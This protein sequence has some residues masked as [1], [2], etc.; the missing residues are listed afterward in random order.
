MMQAIVR[1]PAIGRR[2]L[3]EPEAVIAR[4]A[5]GYAIDFITGPAAEAL[6]PGEAAGFEATPALNTCAPSDSGPVLLRCIKVRFLVLSSRS[7]DRSSKAAMGRISR[8]PSRPATPAPSALLSSAA[9]SSHD[10][11]N[12]RKSAL[13]MKSAGSFL[14]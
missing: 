5:F 10:H 13:G 4:P 11:T 2:S 14:R 1:E 6:F 12:L 8:S 9:S 3:R 7:Q